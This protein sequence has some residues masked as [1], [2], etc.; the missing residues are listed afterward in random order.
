MKVNIYRVVSQGVVNY[1][2]SQKAE[3]GQVAMC[4]IQFKVFGNKYGDEFSCTVFGNLAQ[5]RF[6]EN[7]IVAASLRFVV[8]EFEGRAYQEVLV[9]DI[10][11]LNR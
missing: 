10:V 1:V 5:C 9:E 6:T 4:R 3:N 2:P 11:K 7:D 8:H